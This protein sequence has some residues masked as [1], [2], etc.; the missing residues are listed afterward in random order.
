MLVTPMLTMSAVCSPTVN[1]EAP[2]SEYALATRVRVAPGSLAAVDIAGK[3]FIR[4]GSEDGDAASTSDDTG[5]LCR[6]LTNALMPCWVPLARRGPRAMVALS[7]GRNPIW[8]GIS[9]G[10]VGHRSSGAPC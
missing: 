6:S 9:A 8:V 7:G 10:V 5:R 3:R 4:L 1:S 2:A